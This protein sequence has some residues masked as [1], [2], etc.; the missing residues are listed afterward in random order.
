LDRGL[1]I[2]DLPRGRGVVVIEP[3]KNM[4]PN[5]FSPLSLGE[6]RLRN[7]VVML[8]MGTRFTQEGSVTLDEVE[9]YR[10]RAANGVALITIGGSEVGGLGSSHSGRWK[11]PYR[12]EFVS[13]FATLA[14]AVKA[15]GAQIIG[16]LWHR[17]S[18]PGSGAGTPIVSP[19]GVR[20]RTSPTV[21]HTLSTAEAAGV[22]GAF[23]RS[24]ENLLEAGFDGI[25]IHGAHGYLVNE[26]LSP[27]TNSR[28]DEYGENG[29]HGRATFL[30]EILAR[31][32]SELGQSFPLGVRI[33]ADEEVEDGMRLPDTTD[34]ARR[35]AATGAIQYLSIA[36]GVFGHYIK[37]MSHPVNA[38]EQHCR[39][40]R[41]ATG[42]PVISSQRI[43]HPT[44]A[45]SLL[46][47]GSAD[48]IGLG[49]P[50]IADAEWVRHAASGDLGR[51]VPCV[52]LLQDCRN[53]SATIGCV[54]N[55]TS[56]RER[57]TSPLIPA[58]K[59]QRVA[60]IGG[61]PAGLE[62]ARVAAERGHAVEVFERGS[63][64]GGQVALASQAPNRAEIDGVVGYRVDELR[65]LRV[66]V[67]LRTEVDAAMV[68]GLHADVVV[69]ATGARPRLP[70][71]PYVSDQARI[72]TSFDVHRPDFELSGAR[73]AA[74]VDSGDGSWDAY[75]AA[76]LLAARGLRVHVI[77]PA[78]NPAAGIPAESLPPL[79]RR[80]RRAGVEVRSMSAVSMVEAGSVHVYDPFRVEATGLLEEVALDADLV[81]VAGIREPV[82]EL[83]IELEGRLAILHSVGDCVTPNGISG[84]IR[85]AYNLAVSL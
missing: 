25:E 74:V 85:Q 16:Q 39:T 14:S 6:L 37:D 23:V 64:L 82:S 15:E 79:L 28:Q 70:D 33:T 77:S 1:R 38:T 21:P 48:L 57:T 66:S 10:A 9:F 50:L 3:G 31:I 22:V 27:R 69:L 58:R 53:R 60:I 46:A 80:L 4:L 65:R 59:V 17:G 84:A 83:A 36:V 18:Q 42:L 2:Q 47:S 45:E 55:A 13:S 8:P 29:P 75:G 62:V 11:Q 72:V 19:S 76:E 49:R 7:R 61:G 32:R 20:T 35:L 63:Q 73:T 52:G 51:I 81:V 43:N 26:F 44:N 67:H 5:L 71:I 78:A 40:I 41:E 24:A 54:H 34:L 56:G 12:S 30:F 68:Q